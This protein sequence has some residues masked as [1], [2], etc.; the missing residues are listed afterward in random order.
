[1][2]GEDRRYSGDG[3][4]KGGKD[5]EKESEEPTEMGS[6]LRPQGVGTRTGEECDMNELTK[7]CGNVLI[8]GV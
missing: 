3:G 6:E 7:E 1:M 2:R 8:G 4:S 5:Y